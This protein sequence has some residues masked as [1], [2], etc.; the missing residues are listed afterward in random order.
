LDR[1]RHVAALVVEQVDADV[2][3]M[4]RDIDA[5]AFAEREREGAGER[6]GAVVRVLR[7]CVDVTCVL[8]VGDGRV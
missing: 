4:S 2:P 8:G 5:G 6:E 3:S 7:G 1:V